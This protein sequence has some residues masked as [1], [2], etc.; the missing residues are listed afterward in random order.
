MKIYEL[1]GIRGGAPIDITYFLVV[2]GIE[3][4]YVMRKERDPETS[5]KKEVY[6]KAAFEGSDR[7]WHMGHGIEAILTEV[8]EEKAKEIL[9]KIRP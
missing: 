7:T 9:N 6:T 1:K 5:E 2:D 8:A 3:E 4:V